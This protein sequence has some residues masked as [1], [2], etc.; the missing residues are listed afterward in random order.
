[1]LPL[2]PHKFK[3]S[4][5]IHFFHWNWC[6]H[7]PS[8]TSVD[9]YLYVKFGENK[10]KKS[11]VISFRIYNL[12]YIICK[13]WYIFCGKFMLK[14]MDQNIVVCSDMNISQDTEGNQFPG[15]CM[16]LSNA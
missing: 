8:V 5:I 7:K 6:A 16:V 13:K 11:L 15:L 2:F 10:K 1:M 3:A 4:R 14:F 9:I 12:S